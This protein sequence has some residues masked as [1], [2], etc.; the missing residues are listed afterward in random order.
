[1]PRTIDYTVK[2][3]YTTTSEKII[4][5]QKIGA[6][7]ARFV[8]ESDNRSRRIIN[9]GQAGAKLAIKG[10]LKAGVPFTTTSYNNI[11]NIKAAV[12]RLKK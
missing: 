7:S 10:A 1:M 6:Y 11:T 2:P 9:S 5:V 3:G 4:A 8:T 12:N